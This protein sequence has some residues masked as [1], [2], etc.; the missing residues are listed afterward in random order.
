MD[1]ELSLGNLAL[2]LYRLQGMIYIY[3]YIYIY[4]IIYTYIC[5]R[6]RIDK[7][8]LGLGLGVQIWKSNSRGSKA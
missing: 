1:E 2:E 6:K 4:I 7:E 3:I 5:F 8:L